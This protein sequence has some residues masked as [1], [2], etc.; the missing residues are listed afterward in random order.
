MKYAPHSER[1]RKEWCTLDDLA[2]PIKISISN[3]KKINYY[4]CHVSCGISRGFPELEKL[5]NL[6]QASRNIK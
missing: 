3:F 5:S 6:M 1:N 2:V 4:I